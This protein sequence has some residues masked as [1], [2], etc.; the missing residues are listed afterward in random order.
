MRDPAFLAECRA[1]TQVLAGF[2]TLKG[3]R[4]SPQGPELEARLQKVLHVVR[5]LTP[6]HPPPDSN[7][8]SGVRLVHWNIEHGNWYEQVEDALR[9]QVQLASADVLLLNEIDFGMARAG[10]RDVAADLVAALGL[11]GVWAPLFLETTAGRD[12]DL[13]MAAGRENAESLFGLAILSRWPF[14][15]VRVVELPSPV[16]YQFDRERMYG[17]NIGLVAEIRRPQEPFVAVSTH[18]EV[19][20]T[21]AHRAAQ[22]DVLLDALRGESRPIVLAGDLNTHTFDRG[23][24]LDPWRAAIALLT[25]SSRRLGKRLLDPERGPMRE[26]LFDALREANFEWQRLNDRLPTLNL[27]FDRLDEARGALGWLAPFSRPVLSVAERRAKL[28]LDWFA[29]RGWREMRGATVR[30]LNGPE[31]ASDHAPLV[32]RLE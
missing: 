29:A 17:R 4:R 3:L 32:A 18:L 8:P 14:G 19:H 10:N 12:D 21:R 9:N 31:K 1:L 23:R 28:R 11:Y 25:W 16:H 15:E 27:R 20:R 7:D 6:H 13:Q 26:G 22:M 2:H 24:A 5:H 30:G